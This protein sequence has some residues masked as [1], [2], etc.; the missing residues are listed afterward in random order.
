MNKKSRILAMS[1]F[2]YVGG[3]MFA[4]ICIAGFFCACNYNMAVFNP[5][6]VA[7]MATESPREDF[8][9]GEREHRFFVPC[10]KI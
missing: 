4:R 5:R 1:K 3:L 6:S 8:D 2:S 7:V 10:S 9:S